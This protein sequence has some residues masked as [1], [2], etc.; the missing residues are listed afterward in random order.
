MLEVSPVF[1]S[2]L[3][4]SRDLQPTGAP[5]PRARALPGLFA[6]FGTGCHAAC[7]LTLSS[8]STLSFP[9]AHCALLFDP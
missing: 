2:S 6:G 1:L 9:S 8:S 5:P 3:P 7:F 4:A